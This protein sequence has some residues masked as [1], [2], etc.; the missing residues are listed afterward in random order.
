MISENCKH[1]HS[2]LRGRPPEFCL[3]HGVRP[4]QC[5]P[6]IDAAGSREVDANRN[7]Q[8][9]REPGRRCRSTQVAEMDEA[10]PS[11]VRAGRPRSRGGVIRWHHSS[12]PG[13]NDWHVQANRAKKTAAWNMPP[14]CVFP[15]QEQLVWI[16]RPGTPGASP[17]GG[18]GVVDLAATLPLEV[19]AVQGHHLGPGRD[20]VLH[21]VFIGVP[22]R[23]ELGH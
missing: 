12:L 4:R 21:E 16:S 6:I 17:F 18:F 3:G 8:A 10:V 22:G 20:E 15:D 7:G 13:W 23:V 5:L 2:C 9:G 14:F 11:I 1:F 19:E